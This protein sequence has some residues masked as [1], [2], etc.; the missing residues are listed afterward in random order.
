MT[1]LSSIEYP[2]W[3]IIG[4]VALLIFGLVGLAL[5]QRAAGAEPLA[6]VSAEDSYASEAELNE[7]EFYNRV[8]KQKRRERWAETPA[9]DEPIEAEAQIQGTK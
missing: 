3:L 1:A 6:D 5:R 7:V 8:A 4:G 2:H 9:D